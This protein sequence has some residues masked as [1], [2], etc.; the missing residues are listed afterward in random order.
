M[1][2]RLSRSLFNTRL[3]HFIMM[4]GSYSSPLLPPF[5][6]ASRQ[7]QLFINC[8]I[9]D[10][11]AQRRILRRRARSQLP[12]INHFGHVIFWFFSLA[13]RLSCL[14]S[15]LLLLLAK[16]MRS[17]NKGEKH[18]VHEWSSLSLFAMR[19]LPPSGFWFVIA[20]WPD[21]R[22]GCHCSTSDSA[23]RL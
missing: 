7:T 14:L 13:L 17:T 19:K 22:G 1:S 2:Q 8:T 3:M 10:K 16:Q 9:E 15:L 23:L 12:R 21:K 18:P 4:P 5:D 11:L 20:N 6:L